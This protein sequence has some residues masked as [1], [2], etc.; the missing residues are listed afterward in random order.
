MDDTIGFTSNTSQSFTS[1]LTGNKANVESEF[2]ERF[3]ET[4]S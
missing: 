2:I 3:F 1:T 4:Q